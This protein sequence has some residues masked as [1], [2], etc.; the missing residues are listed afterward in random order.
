MGPTDETAKLLTAEDVD[1]RFK[2]IEVETL[3]GR[4]RTMRLHFP[5]WRRQ[6]ELGLMFIKTLDPTVFFKDVLKPEGDN[7]DAALNGLAPESVAE[8]E[9]LTLAIVLGEAGQ[10]KMSKMANEMLASIVSAKDSAPSLN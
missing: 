3:D 1:N 2:D 4:H 10:K 8:V 9:N 5:T 7:I 6:R